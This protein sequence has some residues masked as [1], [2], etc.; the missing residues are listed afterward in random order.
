MDMLV[1][2]GAIISVVGLAGLL[3]CIF[4]AAQ[5]KKLGGTQ[6]EMHA[7]L[8]PLIPLNLGSLF[9]SIVGLICVIIGVILG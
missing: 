9:L 8:E 5:A 1:M 7:R 4:K 3:L 6:E 2:A